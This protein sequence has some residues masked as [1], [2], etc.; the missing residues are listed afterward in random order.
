M[1]PVLDFEGTPQNPKQEW[2]K[3]HVQEKNIL[4]YM[5]FTFA[6][7]LPNISQKTTISQ[8][9]S[10]NQNFTTCPCPEVV[11]V[12]LLLLVHGFPSPLDPWKSLS[13]ESCL[14]SWKSGKLGP[15]SARGGFSWWGG[16]GH[17]VF[18]PRLRLGQSHLTSS[19]YWILL[20]AEKNP[21]ASWGI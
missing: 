1:K 6:N 2:A 10:W 13:D 5:S 4:C 11:K 14:R 20:M 21:I 17:W 19:Y 8:Q 9:I 3:L 12:S 16:K 7:N 18:S 15:A